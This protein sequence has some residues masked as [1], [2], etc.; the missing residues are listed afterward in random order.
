MFLKKKKI[1]EDEKKRR[2]LYLKLKKRKRISKKGVKKEKKLK[3]ER[4]LNIKLNN[5]IFI[6]F[7]KC[8]NT[9]IHNSRNFPLPVHINN[10]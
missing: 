3:E 4:S 5:Y 2:K 9:I 8:L 7:F 10:D 1:K 6:K